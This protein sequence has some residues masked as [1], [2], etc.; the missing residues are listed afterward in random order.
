MLLEEIGQSLRHVPPQGHRCVGRRRTRHSQTRR[1]AEAGPP[2]SVRCSRGRTRAPDPPQD[3]RPYSYFT[4]EREAPDA[5]S[6]QSVEA[7]LFHESKW[8]AYGLLYSAAFERR[9]DNYTRR[10][11][12]SRGESAYNVRTNTDTRRTRCGVATDTRRTDA[13]SATVT[14]NSMRRRYRHAPNRRRKMFA[15]NKNRYRSRYRNRMRRR[16]RS[17]MR[18]KKKKNLCNVPNHFE[19]STDH[20]QSARKALDDEAVLVP[21][22]G[23]F[24]EVCTEFREAIREWNQLRTVVHQLG[25]EPGRAEKALLRRGHRR[26]RLWLCRAGRG[27]HRGEAGLSG[28]CAPSAG[29]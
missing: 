23:Y 4:T 9:A 1:S 3:A 18:H 8:S 2:T 19:L 17:R 22:A 14:P 20:P 10:R 13:A 16:Y 15:Q 27:L 12:R 11:R 25:P 5:S 7:G 28:G 6:R 21:S 26:H 24:T 29:A